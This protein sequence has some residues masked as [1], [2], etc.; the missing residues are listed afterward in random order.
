LN[1]QEFTDKYVVRAKALQAATGAPPD[2]RL[3]RFKRDRFMVLG[4]ASERVAGDVG[5]VLKAG[6]NLAY[7]RC[8]PNKG[9]CPHKHADWEIFVVLSSHWKVTVGGDTEVTVGPLDVVAVPG[10]V[11]HEAVNIGHD[12]GYMMSINMGTDSAGYVIHPSIL[13]E[14]RLQAPDTQ[15]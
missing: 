10:D 5:P 7:V 12:G 15:S 11:F 9:F 2:A 3:P 6:I 13:E 4:R 8:D 14:L 1:L